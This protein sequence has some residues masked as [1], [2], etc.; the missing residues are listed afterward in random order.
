MSGE[1][2]FVIPAVIS[3]CFFFCFSKSASSLFSRLDLSHAPISKHATCQHSSMQ[4]AAP[5][6]AYF[7]LSGA[8]SH[9]SSAHALSLWG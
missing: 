9:G 3:R 6:S 2:F 5:T 8:A 4:A 1:G 7:V